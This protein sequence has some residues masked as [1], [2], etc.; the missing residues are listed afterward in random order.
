VEVDVADVVVVACRAGP[1]VPV[2][3]PAHAVSNSA[4]MIV[5]VDL[6][7]RHSRTPDKVERAFKN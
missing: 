7:F 5:A 6:M 4:T 1:V 2:P 3:F